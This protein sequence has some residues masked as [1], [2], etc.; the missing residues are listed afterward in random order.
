MQL[1]SETADDPHSLLEQAADDLGIDSLVAV[2]IRSWFLRELEVNVPVLKI[3]GG[4]T[5]EEIVAYAVKKLPSELARGVDEQRQTAAISS[6]GS[7]S[8]SSTS[9]LTPQHS[10]PASFTLEDATDTSSSGPSPRREPSNPPM[11]FLSETTISPPAVKLHT[12]EK[13]IPMSFGQSRFWFMSRLA[14]DQTAFNVTCSMLVT[15]EVK[16]QDL[17]RAVRDLGIRHEAL[18]TCFFNNDKHQSMQ[19]ILLE[20]PLHLETL[21]VSSQ[22]DVQDQFQ[23]LK[24]HVYDLEKGETMRIIL[25]SQS[26]T[27]HFLLCGYH[28]INMDGTSLVVLLSDLQ[29]LYV[30]EKMSPPYL[31][32][33][34]FSEQ[35]LSRLHS[36]EWDNEIAFWRKE[37]DDLPDTL[38]ILNVSPS[39]S[40]LREPL[41][42][43][44]HLKSETR[45][46]TQT[47]SKIRSFCRKLKVTPFHF[48]CA[49]FQVTL[50]RLASIEDVCIG[51]ADANRTDQGAMECIGMFLNVFPVRLR[52]SLDQPFSSIIRQTKKKILSG[53]ANSAV[54]FDVI[55]NKVGVKRSPTHSPLFQAFIDYRQVNEK[56]RFGNGELEGQEYAI[57]E[58]PYDVMLDIVDNPSGN[59]SVAIM[60]QEGLYEKENADLVLQCYLNLVQAF[61]D[62]SELLGGEPQMF[63]TVDVEHALKLSQGEFPSHS[64]LRQ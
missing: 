45:I 20:S 38:P 19:G 42:T 40:R 30:G 11:P 17:A 22:D 46:N 5:I 47:A 62:N 3:L 14:A 54:P 6:A 57:G 28:H 55:L 41:T 43:Y 15:G 12:I 4:A 13:I 61:A 51:V 36:G 2:E 8:E 18:R 25:L 24:G 60:V 49:I 56:Q 9:A 50:A 58:T 63:N 16:I 48:Y 52:T 29:K 64:S 59:A 44:R 34:D 31:Q 7:S 32:Y 1:R 35:Q 26:R 23:E 39:S 37:F 27:R 21:N 10:T 53:L 33:P